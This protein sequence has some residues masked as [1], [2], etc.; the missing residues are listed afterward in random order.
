MKQQKHTFAFCSLESLPK[1]AVAGPCPLPCHWPSQRQDSPL[2]CLILVGAMWSCLEKRIIFYYLEKAPG[3]F[4]I[5]CFGPLISQRMSA[6]QSLVSSLFCRSVLL[7]LLAG[8]HNLISAIALVWP[9]ILLF[10]FTGV[11]FGSWLSSLSQ[12]WCF[13]WVLSTPVSKCGVSMFYMYWGCRS[14]CN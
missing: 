5:A 3:D 10:R 6:L 4:V 14:W 9:C 2:S 11:L 7:Q 8:R 12:K 13:P 1:R